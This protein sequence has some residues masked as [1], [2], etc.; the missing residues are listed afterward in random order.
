MREKDSEVE[1]DAHKHLQTETDR[2]VAGGYTTL[3]RENRIEQ[4]YLSGLAT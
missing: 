1:R 3:A 4:A 2:T